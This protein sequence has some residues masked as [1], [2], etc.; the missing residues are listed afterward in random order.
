MVTV[1]ETQHDS[2]GGVSGH[3]HIDSDDDD[4]CPSSPGSPSFDDGALMA[5]AMGHDVT[6]QLAAAGWQTIHGTFLFAFFSP[7]LFIFIYFYLHY[8]YWY[9]YV[10]HVLV[11]SILK[12]TVFFDDGFQTFMH[13][14]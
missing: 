5:A 4:D 6:A 3:S 7:H 14:S 11:N 12:E 8:I 10:L 9:R 2:L 1:M 13:H